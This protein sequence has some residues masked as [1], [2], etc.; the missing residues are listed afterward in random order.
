MFE[1]G[2]HTARTLIALTFTDGRTETVSVRLGLTAK[3]QD[4]LNNGDMPSSTSS[5]PPTSS[6]SW[7]SPAFCVSSWWKFPRPAR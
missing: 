1:S 6:T 4:S 3:L 5:M 2:K 7:P